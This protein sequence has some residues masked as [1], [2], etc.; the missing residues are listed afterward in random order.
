[1][2]IIFKNVFY[3]QFFILKLLK[4]LGFEVF[5]LNI[6]ANSEVKK[7]ELALKL[8]KKNILPLPIE[9]EEKFPPKVSYSDFSYDSNEISYKKNLR[10]SPDKILEQYCDLF[11]LKKENKT[12]LRLLMQDFVAQMQKSILATLNLWSTLYPQKKILY[13]SFS[14]KCFYLPSGEK[15]MF[16]VIVPFDFLNFFFKKIKTIVFKNKIKTKKIEKKIFKKQNE[17]FNSK[18]L[19]IVTH[20][21]LS[22]GP[23]GQ[24][25]FDKSLYYSNDKNSVFNKYNI[26]HLD[27]SN[28]PTPDV[29]LNWVYLNQNKF[30]KLSYISKIF[31][32][33]IKKMYLINNFQTFLGWVF[34][35]QQYSIFLK[36]HESIK[37][38]KNLKIAI[39]D[40]DILCPKTLILALERNN[41]KTVAVQER[42][43]TA[44]C[45]SYS[46]VMLD[47]YYVSSDYMVNIIKNS[48]YYVVKN[49]KAIGQYRATYISSYKSEK[50]IPDEI[51]QAKKEGKKIII[52]FGI[53][54]P[55]NWF[56]MYNNLLGSWNDQKSFLEDFIKLSQSLD[57]TFIVLRYKDLSWM[58]NEYFKDTF[59]K[60]KNC[61]NLKISD[62][63]NESFYVY[64][65]CAN[66]DLVIAKHTSVV[67]ECLANEIP[68][69]VHDYTNKMQKMYS[70]IKNY[71]PSELMCHSYQELNEKS[72]SI[73]FSDSSNLNKI[74]K[75]LSK[76]IYYVNEKNNF[77]KKL[78]SDLSNQLN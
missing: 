75:E 33:A 66:A 63:Y 52:G 38:F 25:L 64:K 71:L 12:K 42:F 46:N 35:V 32:I 23:E 4:F 40:N 47:T 73:L 28:F 54:C 37:K 16:K 6:I 20:M 62:H 39:I 27:Y 59:I 5:Y 43:I 11:Y 78:F 22:Y 57:D 65:L 55:K 70:D 48:K 1:M 8:K 49:I 77:K 31:F 44:Y 56:Q 30:S 41:I 26:L 76:K 14:F 74:V 7:N 51:S 72:K 9:L 15:N 17:N 19:A 68:V 10:L 58:N 50:I 29:N 2:H 53:H 34:F 60:L 61:K 67:D 3:W 69:L 21:G 24:V 18:T 36:Y 45:T 13:I